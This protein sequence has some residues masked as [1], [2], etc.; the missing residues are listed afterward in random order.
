[1]SDGTKSFLIGAGILGLLMAWGLNA[2]SSSPTYSTPEST[3]T[4][5]TTPETEEVA[6]EEPNSDAEPLTFNGYE[7]TDDCSGHE[8]G[9]QWAED[10]DVCDEEFDGGNSES[11]NEGVRSYAEDYCY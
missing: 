1:M 4:S 10:N 3:T 8:A 5:E 9:Y 2:A 6:E 7:C 11:F